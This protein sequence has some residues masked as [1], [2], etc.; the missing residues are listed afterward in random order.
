MEGIRN[1]AREMILFR[2]M[3][4]AVILTLT[5]C[6]DTVVPET[7]LNNKD[8]SVAT[9]YKIKAGDNTGTVAC[10]RINVTEISQMTVLQ[11]NQLVTIVAVEE[12]L[13]RFN[14]ELWLHIYPK[15]SHRPSCYVNVNNLIPYS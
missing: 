12:G 1:M 6:D 2:L 11:E 13:R 10:F 9:L 15:L 3:L 8:R 5:G 4:L 7:D 14:N